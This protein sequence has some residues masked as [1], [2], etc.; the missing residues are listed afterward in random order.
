MEQ[1]RLRENFTRTRRTR[2]QHEQRRLTLLAW[3]DSRGKLAAAAAP[4]AASCCVAMAAVI[5]GLVC[6]FVLLGTSKD[7]KYSVTVTGAAGLDPV[8]DLSSAAR[9]RLS[10]VFNLTVRIDNAREGFS[11]ACVAKFAVATVSYADAPLARGS[12][13]QICARKTKVRERA[14]KAWGDGVALPRFLR[15][16][17]PRWPASWRRGRRRWTSR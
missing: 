17:M 14:V 2:R 11:S 15:G 10:P 8:A 1:A 13:P 12:V 4:L 3:P 5:A 9:P 7:A 16:Q 6:L